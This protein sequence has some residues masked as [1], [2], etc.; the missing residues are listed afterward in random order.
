MSSSNATASPSLTS[1]INRTSSA[2]SSEVP[3]GLSSLRD[4]VKID[5]PAEVPVTRLTRQNKEG[6]VLSLFADTSPTLSFA[7]G[8]EYV[9]H[10]FEKSVACQRLDEPISHS[11]RP[12]THRREGGQSAAHLRSRSASTIS[13]QRS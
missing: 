13:F 12:S 11:N 4:I 3:A 8:R 1:C 6:F 9:H 5:V 10:E 2:S 7:T